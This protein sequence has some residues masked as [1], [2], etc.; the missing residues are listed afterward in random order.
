M[1]L[2]NKMTFLEHAEQLRWRLIRI[3]IVIFF[4]ML[5]SFAYSDIIQAFILYPIQSFN[6]ENLG[7][8]FSFIAS[9]KKKPAKVYN[10]VAPI[11]VAVSTINIPHHLPKTKPENIKRG[12][13]KPKS[14]T[15]I[16][17]NI[18]KIIERNKKFSFLY[19]KIISL[20]TL[21]NS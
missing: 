7:A 14:K 1:K 2:G 12:I 9:L 4:L 20:F 21:I 17:E 18:K 5:I 3:F 6:L 13:A 15:Q 10:K 11:V 19:S 16:M 8:N